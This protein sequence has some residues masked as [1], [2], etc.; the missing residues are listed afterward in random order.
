MYGIHYLTLYS[1]INTS[2]KNLC[3]DSSKKFKYLDYLSD[4]KRNL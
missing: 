1:K 2:M 3:K 4:I